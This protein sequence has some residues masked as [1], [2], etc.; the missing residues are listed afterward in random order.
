MIK[1]GQALIFA[2][3]LILGALTLGITIGSS[4]Q[5]GVYEKELAAITQAESDESLDEIN[6]KL[7]DILDELRRFY[8]GQNVI[9]SWYGEAFHG[10]EMA[11]GKP[12]DMHGYTCAH[13]TLPLGS[14]VLIEHPTTGRFTIATVRDRGPFIGSRKLDVSYKVAQELG[15]VNEGICLVKLTVL[16]RG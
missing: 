15:M 13:R 10:K 6:T 11:N 14:I 8:E 3:F 1:T 12:F 2:S 9:A 4:V 7:G 16:K 5:K